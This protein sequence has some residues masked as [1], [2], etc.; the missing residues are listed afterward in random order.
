MKRSG[1]S[2]RHISHPKMYLAKQK[3]KIY[4]NSLRTKTSL[5]SQLKKGA[6]FLLLIRIIKHVQ[7]L[8]TL[9]Q[10]YLYI[11]QLYRALPVN[12]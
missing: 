9:P 6:A 3:Q 1:N 7:L 2:L 12:S 11:K 10:K 5:F 8:T 4:G